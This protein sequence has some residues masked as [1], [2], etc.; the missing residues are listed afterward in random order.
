M[1]DIGTG[2]KHK[3]PGVSTMLPPL[4]KLNL[5]PSQGSEAAQEKEM[6]HLHVTV[7]AYSCTFKLMVRSTLKDKSSSH[8]REHQRRPI[9]SAHRREDKGAAG[10]NED[11]R[12]GD[13]GLGTILSNT[14][15]ISH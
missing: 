4:R 13:G 3:A 8:P 2:K 7:L 5:D 6:P 11:R 14:C 12:R 15:N 10:M 1:Q 9:S